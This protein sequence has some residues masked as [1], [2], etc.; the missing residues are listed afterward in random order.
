MTLCVYLDTNVF[1]EAFEDEGL[2]KEAARS[3][4]FKVKDRLI[5]AVTSELIVA[6]LLVRPLQLGRE[7]LV[8][9][10]STLVELEGSC[11]VCPIDRSTLVEAARQRAINPA[12]KLPDAIH[13]ATARLQGC[14]VFLTNDARLRMPPGLIRVGLNASTLSDLQAL[15]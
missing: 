14:K 4:F 13:I 10:Y 11:S 5:T 6:E 2:L 12:I 1:I 15:A 3:V 7:E 8:D 9:A